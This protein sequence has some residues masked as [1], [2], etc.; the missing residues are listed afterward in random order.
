MAEITF[1]TA[2]VNGGYITI[3]ANSWHRHGVTRLTD[4]RFLTMVTQTSPNMFIFGVWDVTNQKS[5][6]PT[7]THVR[8]QAVIFNDQYSSVMGYPCLCVGLSAEYALVIYTGSS[9][10][11]TAQVIHIDPINGLITPK[12][13]TTVV[14]SGQYLYYSVN[15]LVQPSNSGS[16]YWE[17]ARYKQADNNVLI[18]VRDGI[19]QGSNVGLYRFVYDPITNT[20]TRTQILSSAVSSGQYHAAV[21]QPIPG[22]SDVLYYITCAADPSSNQTW[23]GSVMGVPNQSVIYRVTPSGTT[24]SL[25]TSTY[26]GNGALAPLTASTMVVVDQAN[27]SRHFSTST[28]LYNQYSQFASNGGGGN[29]IPVH[30]I[31]ISDAYYAF[32]S[33]S[34]VGT[35]DQR[36]QTSTQLFFRVVKFTDKNVSQ[37]SP[38]TAGT[39]SSHGGMRL[40]ANK[41]TSGATDGTGTNPVVWYTDAT[42][43]DQTN[44]IIGI[45]MAVNS[46]TL[47]IKFIY[48]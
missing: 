13:S 47:G 33:S 9:A 29:T 18:S 6:T 41:T 44:N 30:M 15:N 37:V 5:A 11:A 24:A 1:P 21:I 8:Q 34:D 12:L 43:H 27:S 35:P 14:F 36:V 17:G 16:M 7:T 23:R 20:L 48:F 25:V 26:Y 2:P 46:T 42:Y 28:G 10:N 40:Y 32:L 38:G 4:T 39:A 19:G 22:S 45:P 31:P 3:D